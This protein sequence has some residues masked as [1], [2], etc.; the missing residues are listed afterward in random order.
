MS[1]LR[2]DKVEEYIFA[3]FNTFVY[4]DEDKLR[5]TGMTSIA[6]DLIDELNTNPPPTGFEGIFIQ[7]DMEDSEAFKLSKGVFA[8]PGTENSFLMTKLVNKN[9]EPTPIQLPQDIADGLNLKPLAY[10]DVHFY[11]QDCGVATLSVKIE[12]EKSGGLSIL[13]LE[14]VSESVNN[15]IKEYFEELCFNL[16]RQYI[17]AIRKFD[18]PR[19]TFASIPEIDEIERSK[20]FIPWTHR[21]YHISDDTMFDIENP[22]EPFK[23]LLTPSRQMDIKDLSIYDN[24]WIYFGWGHSIIFTHSEEDGYS[25]TSRPVYDYVRLVEIAQA[26]WQFWTS[27]KISSH[28]LLHH[29]IIYTKQ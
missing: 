28:M 8:A 26:N 16:A 22:G 13:E 3:P 7:W 5:L 27:L 25:Q 2:F 14:Q 10:S 6:Q 29:S 19:H 17:Q 21:I 23:V 1:E 20:H 24:R 15:L 4:I 9:K 12:I 18:T 11:F